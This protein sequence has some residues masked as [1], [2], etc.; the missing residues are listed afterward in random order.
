MV[1]P[2]GELGLI[3]RAVIGESGSWEEDDERT[4]HRTEPMAAF[5]APRLESSHT[6]RGYLPKV[7]PCHVHFFLAFATE[8]N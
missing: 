6:R 4:R 7:K 1:T 5:N 8:L 2:F 3:P